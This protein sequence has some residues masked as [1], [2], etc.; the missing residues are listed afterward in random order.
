MKRL[1]FFLSSL[2]ATMMMF[3]GFTTGEASASENIQ[4]KVDGVAVQFPD[5]KPFIDSKSSRTLVPLRF[6]SEKLGA[7]VE[8]DQASQT[9]K[10]DKDGKKI[11][12]KVGEKEATIGDSNYALETPAIIKEERTFVPLRFISR[13]FDAL[14]RWD[15]KQR[16]VTVETNPEIKDVT[17]NDFP[18]QNSDQRFQ[19]FHKNLQ[20]KNGVLTGKVPTDAVSIRVNCIVYFKDGYGRPSQVIKP[21]DSFTFNVKDVKLF[22]ITITDQAKKQILASFTY[23]D[24]PDL[25]AEDNSI[26]R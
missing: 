23:R 22:G 21:G 11:S 14:V 20:I 15:G 19:T 17:G 9:V 4:V 25:I 10:I 6:I 1:N 12:L 24:L 26:M 2:V 3:T 7:N 18:V 13:A 16:L 5:A 8:W